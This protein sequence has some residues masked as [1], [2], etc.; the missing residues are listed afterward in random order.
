V[1]KTFHFLFLGG[2]LVGAQTRSIPDSAYLPVSVDRNAPES[3]EDVMFQMRE[4]GDRILLQDLIALID[5]PV[6]MR[7]MAAAIARLSAS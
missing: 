1:G 2:V 4:N 5:F 3:T 6:T 7:T